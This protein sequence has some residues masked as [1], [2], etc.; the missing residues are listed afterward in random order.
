[1]LDSRTN[2]GIEVVEEIKNHFKENPDELVIFGSNDYDDDDDPL[3]T[4]IGKRFK[5]NIL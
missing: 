4:K 1:M 5:I 2:L 3:G